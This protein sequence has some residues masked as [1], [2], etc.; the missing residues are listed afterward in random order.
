[1]LKIKKTVF[2]VKSNFCIVDAKPKSILSKILSIPKS[3]NLT[4]LSVCALAPFPG[5]V[6]INTKLANKVKHCRRK[7]H[8][9][10]F[11]TKK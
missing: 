5:V 6:K 8:L 3:L 2:P 10:F 7:A 9:S 11:T 4:K 1:M